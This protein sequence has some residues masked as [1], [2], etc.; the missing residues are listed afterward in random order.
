M[1]WLSH[2]SYV[3]DEAP[4]L[5]GVAEVVRAVLSQ[6]VGF[7]NGAGLDLHAAEDEAG[8]EDCGHVR[9]GERDG[10]GRDD[11]PGEDGMAH[12]A[13]LAGGDERCGL[14]LVNTDPPRGSECELGV[15]GS[16][17]GQAKKCEPCDADGKALE[18][19]E[20]VEPQQLDDGGDSTAGEPSHHECGGEA[21]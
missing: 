7:F 17:D 20:A 13:E 4:D 15:E 8:A 21:R 6:E 18:G 2:R 19:I 11:H 10:S 12:E 3:G 14:A 1:E 16:N 9:H 5:P